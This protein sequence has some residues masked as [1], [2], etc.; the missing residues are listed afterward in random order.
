M[1]G[2]TFVGDLGDTAVLYNMDLLNKAGI[3]ALPKT[4]PSS[5]PRRS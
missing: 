4:G 2:T 5:T 3:T 1:V